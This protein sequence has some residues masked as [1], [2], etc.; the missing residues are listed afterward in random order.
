MTEVYFASIKTLYDDQMFRNYYH[1]ITAERRARVEKFHTDGDKCRGV[2]A[3]LL[4][5][6]GLQKHGLS[7]LEAKGKLRQV[8]LLTGPHG[9]P[10]LQGEQLF[11][12]LSHSGDYVAAA[13]S[14]E[15]VGVDI[16]QVKTANIKIAN[17]FFTK[18]EAE[19]LNE[20]DEE[21]RAQAFT[22][23]WT[24]KESY[25]KAVGM[26]LTLPLNQFSIVNGEH[27]F[28]SWY[29]PKGYCIS[30]CTQEVL[31]NGIHEI[32]LG[33]VFDGAGFNLYN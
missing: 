9:K 12:N 21:I 27:S 33:K 32:D 3:G 29:Q 15:E 13:F 30:V 4:L 22:E 24:R 7:L 18:E 28:F 23:I 5:E 10:K 26:G 11:F 19:Y 31:K 14:T 16:E 6:Y 2:G 25:V 20:V 1:L 8:S 17:R